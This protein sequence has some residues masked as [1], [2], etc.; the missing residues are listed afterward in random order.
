MASSAS[1]AHDDRGVVAVLGELLARAR[2]RGNRSR[3]R[4]QP[5]RLVDD[6]LK[7]VV[8]NP[9]RSRVARRHALRML[10]PVELDRV[11]PRRP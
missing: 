7:Q 10:E 5:I 9:P 2:L 6:D 4:D 1:C 3:V 11:R 8:E